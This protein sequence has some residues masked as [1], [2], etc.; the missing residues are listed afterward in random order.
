[1]CSTVSDFP[2]SK[3]CS[4]YWDNIQNVCHTFGKK[5]TF[6]MFYKR[7][8]VIEG[9]QAGPQQKHQKSLLPET[10][11]LKFPLRPGLFSGA[12]LLFVSGEGVAPP[13]VL[14]KKSSWRNPAPPDRYETL[15]KNQNQDW[16][17][18]QLVRRNS[19]PSTL[20]QPRKNVGRFCCFIQNSN[21]GGCSSL[22]NPNC[23]MR[24]WH[25]LSWRGWWMVILFV[26]CLVVKSAI[27]DTCKF[28]I[29]DFPITKKTI[30]WQTNKIQKQPKWEETT[31]WIPCFWFREVN[32][33]E[34]K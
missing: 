5:S 8:R 25:P 1:M 18:Y 22:P 3:I 6:D 19:E 12:L 16:L 15:F 29:L 23:L 30:V 33:E 26:T 7:N 20:F 10:N 27:L 2:I 34:A 9:S 13:D 14:L 24:W 28:D 32:K 11:S 4:K 17:I 31:W 21:L